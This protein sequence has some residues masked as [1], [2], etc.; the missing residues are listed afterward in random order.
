MSDIKANLDAV[1]Q[2]INA[3]AARAGRDAAEVTMVAV[4][5][6]HPLETVI[7][8]YQAGL[9]HFGENRTDEG[10]QKVTEM[11]QW[12]ADQPGAAPHWH[13]IGHLQTRQVGDI[14]GTFQVIHSLDRVKLADRIQRLAERDNHPPVEVL[15]QCNIS[16]EESKSG[17]E[18]RQWESDAG[19]F[20]AFLEDVTHISQL[21]K[22]NITGLMTMA[23]WLDDV[24]AVRPTFRRL[25]KLRDTLRHEMPH[26]DWT[27]LS[28]GMTDD[29][30]VAIEEGATLVRIGRAL[31]GPRPT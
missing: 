29:F 11:A 23:P 1:Y 4:S 28:M 21:D 9:C 20:T 31:F 12:L 24:E 17:F 18:L 6:T 15:L 25:A 30:E 26:L 22:I 8:A 7:A 27:H 5:K 19:Q 10:P 13:F 2:R 3:A 14:L 16:G